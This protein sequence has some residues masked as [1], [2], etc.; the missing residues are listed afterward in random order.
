MGERSLTKPTNSLYSCVQVGRATRKTIYE[1]DIKFAA[2]SAPLA[3][4]VG[5]QSNSK[6]NFANLRHIGFIFCIPWAELMHSQES[7]FIRRPQ[8]VIKILDIVLVVL[9]KDDIDLISVLGYMKT[10]TMRLMDAQNEVNKLDLPA[11]ASDTLC[12]VWICFNPGHHLSSLLH[13][14]GKA[15]FGSDYWLH[16]NDSMNLF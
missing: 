15:S 12:R 13:G 11:T 2:P 5:S 7:G 10:T 4:P 14:D 16:F 1:L 3:C 8:S 6:Q 9:R